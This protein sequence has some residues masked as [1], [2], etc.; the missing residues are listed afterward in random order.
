MGKGGLYQ[1]ETM[2]AMHDYPCVYLGMIGGAVALTTIAIKAVEG[3]YWKDLFPE[4]IWKL[5]VEN[6]GP[7][8][9][10]IDTSGNNLYLD[11]KKNSQ[12]RIEGI[13]GTTN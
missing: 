4:C 3:V 12:S 13:L 11:V 6:L 1:N 5:R 7:M 2:K 10:G 8:I 9:V